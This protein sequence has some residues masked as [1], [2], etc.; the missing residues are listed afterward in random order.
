MKVCACSASVCIVSVDVHHCAHRFMGR[1]IYIY[2]VGGKGGGVVACV[3]VV[4][5]QKKHTLLSQ[6]CRQMSFPPLLT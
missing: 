3:Y 1:C 6:L 4:S 5:I 2:G